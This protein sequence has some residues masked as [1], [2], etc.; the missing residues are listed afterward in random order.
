MPLLEHQLPVIAAM[1][2]HFR[3]REPVKWGDRDIHPPV[4]CN[5]SVSSGKSIMIAALAL[6]VR[7]AANIRAK[8]AEKKLLLQVLI[9]QGKG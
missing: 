6:A 3:S 5:A 9:M 8:A 7:Q 2:K 4:V 1:Q